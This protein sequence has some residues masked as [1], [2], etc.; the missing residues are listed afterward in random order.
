MTPFSAF[1]FPEL[2]PPPAA[3]V[4]LAQSNATVLDA[5]DSGLV[6]SYIEE[7][8]LQ[9]V[10]VD[11]ALARLKL[12]KEQLRET[13]KTYE[14]CF[15]PIR[16]LI[17]SAV[18][19]ETASESLSLDMDDAPWLLTRIC[20]HWSAVALSTPALW[21]R[22][23]LRLHHIGERGAVS[24]T[25]LQVERSQ[26]MPL[27][28]KISDGS[29]DVTGSTHESHPVFDVALSA[30]AKWGIAD[31]SLH[32]SLLEQISKARRFDSLT[33]LLIDIDFTAD[34]RFQSVSDY[35]D[36]FWNVFSVAPKLRHVQALSWDMEGIFISVPFS[37]PWH[38]LTHLSTSS[39][40][41]TEA[42]TVLQKLSSIV[43]CT[44]AFDVADILQ[45]DHNIV[46]LP[47]LRSL[48]IQ[49]GSGPIIYQKRT[50]VLDF[51]ETPRLQRL[52]VYQTA[53]IE[54]VLGLVTRS[55]C[56]SSLTSLH[57]YSDSINYNMAL[58]L[59]AKMPSLTSL[60]LGE[61]DQR[62]LL[63]RSLTPGFIQAFI[64][65]FS[66]H[67]LKQ[68]SVGDPQPLRL[69]ISNQDLPYSDVERLMSMFT[70]LEKEGLFITVS[71]SIRVPCI[72]MDDFQY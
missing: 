1:T 7:L 13:R 50:S 56:A 59:L 46:S 65:E 72:I 35:D 68:K 62:V 32:P 2:P 45:R 66:K 52:A 15:A 43:E 37:L 4:H 61:Y 40:S 33:T 25:R 6:R 26:S 16:R 3:I 47:H 39:T 48:A 38:Q 20:R 71:L 64:E 44:L 69:L 31:V 67:W 19:Q 57:L 11:E 53:D 23:D 30:S 12:R 14:A 22:L 18:V 24:L 55:N 51:L 42:L 70:R 28:I 36:A 29:Y 54:A 60:E 10:S 8:D 9:M 49:M 17:F 34:D 5:V 58:D 41:N 27:S 21:S 63:T